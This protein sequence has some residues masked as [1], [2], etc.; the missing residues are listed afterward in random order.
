MI[1]REELL[2]RAKRIMGQARE[3][4]EVLMHAGLIPA[5]PQI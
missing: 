5:P 1:S 3:A 2:A 4:T